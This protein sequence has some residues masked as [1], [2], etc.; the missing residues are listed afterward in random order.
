MVK[1]YGK[2]CYVLSPAQ[3]VS[4]L[5]CKYSLYKRVINILTSTTFKEELDI[6][7]L[8]EAYRLLVKR[9]DCLR[10]RFFKKHG[11]LMQF[12]AG[13]N[14]VKVKNIPTLSFNS[15]EEQEAFIDKTRKKPIKYMRGVVIEP[16]YIKT[17]DGRFMIFLKVCHLALDIYG[18]RIM[19]KDLMEIY[20][21]LKN[22]TELP[23]PTGSFEEIVKRDIELSQ[24]KSI[25]QKHIDYFTELFND[26]PEPYYAGIHGPNNKLWQKSLAKNHRAMPIFFVHNDTQTYTHKIDRNMVEKVLNFCRYNQCSPANLLFY[27]SSITLAMMNGNLKNVMPI[28]LY[29]CRYSAAEKN[30]G[31]TKAQ[32]GGCYT[33]INYAL[34]FEENLKIFSAEQF[35]LYK[36]VKFS[37]RD[38]ETLMHNAYRSS[39]LQIY[40]SMA[41]SFF[42][43]EMSEDIEFN[44]YT[45]GK[46]ALP[47]Y[48]IQFLNTKT[49]EIEMSYDVQTK[50]TSEVDVRIFHNHY[51]N[52]LKQVLEDPR[53]K[54][55]DIV[56]SDHA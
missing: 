3:D 16:Y 50:I 23:S 12:F 39:Y 40:Y 21:A 26:N 15:K 44:V 24:N 56:L 41:Y 47:A 4:Y 34:S 7:I 25:T 5:Q 51:L 10:I 43:F 28:G 11:R 46:G 14:D 13:E 31:G 35:R 18:I 32:S 55:S 48:V 27:V 52:V 49:N 53:I 54:I 9:N 22:G 36:H 33:K 6:D 2:P 30:C 37:D 20:D 42:S 19:Y 38:F 8:N 17:Y 29:N 1:T 45:N